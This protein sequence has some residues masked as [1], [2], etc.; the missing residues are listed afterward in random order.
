[1]EN[2]CYLTETRNSSQY[3]K[4]AYGLNEIVLHFAVAFI[5]NPT[6]LDMLVSVTKTDKHQA[7][8]I[9][10]CFVAVTV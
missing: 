9:R 4:L 1:M 2:N 8:W 3:G 5:L 10:V 6:L 7:G